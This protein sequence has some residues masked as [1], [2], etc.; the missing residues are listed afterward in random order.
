V[1]KVLE[2]VDKHGLKGL[3]RYLGNQLRGAPPGTSV[4]SFRAIHLADQILHPQ[5]KF[6][7]IAEAMDLFNQSGFDFVRVLQGMSNTIEEAFG[8][9]AHLFRGKSFSQRDAYTLI[10]LHEQPEGVGFLIKKTREV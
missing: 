1:I 4:S 6:Y 3:G 2:Y 8:P 5:D 10:E 7:R 9:E